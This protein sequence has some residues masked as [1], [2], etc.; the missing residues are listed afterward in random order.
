MATTDSSRLAYWLL[1]DV[2][3]AIRDYHMIQDGDRVAVAVSGGKD[4]LSLLR[5]L[6]IRRK[7]TP[8][9]YSLYAVHVIG[10]ARGP[11][12]PRHLALESWLAESGYSYVVESMVLPEGE[13]L[14]M[15]CHRCTWN[16]RRMLFE[17]AHKLGCN[18]IALGHHTDDLAQT[19]LLNLIFSGRVETMAPVGTYFD[20][21]FQLIRPMIYLHEKEIQRYARVCDFPPGPTKCPRSDHSRRK[22]VGE[23]IQ[24]VEPWCKD[25]RVNLLRAGLQGVKLSA[26]MRDPR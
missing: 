7:A 10:D 1:K 22:R 23:L 17:T 24:L 18:K 12:C 21:L 4:S 26:E 9:K 16:R 13:I 2:D 8:E 3:K 20:G 14:P 25:I 19:T 15:D 5:L 6:D 11:G